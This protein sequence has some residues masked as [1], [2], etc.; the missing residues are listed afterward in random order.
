MKYAHPQVSI[1]TQVLL[2]S[3]PADALRL[4]SK[5]AEKGQGWKVC[6]GQV[7]G[8]DESFELIPSGVIARL[9]VDPTVILDVA[10]EMANET[11]G[12][13][14][15]EWSMDSHTFEVTWGVNS[16]TLESGESGYIEPEGRAM[17]SS[18]GSQLFPSLCDKRRFMALAVLAKACGV[19]VVAPWTCWKCGEVPVLVPGEGYA[20]ACNA[21]RSDDG[22]AE[23][24]GPLPCEFCGGEKKPVLGHLWF[25]DCRTRSR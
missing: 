10:C 11:H 14:S 4:L 20:C 9:P 5:A 7:K 21:E 17:C 25:C 3:L 24:S 22:A 6:L 2:L 19:E 15:A 8:I 12:V 1:H 23:S 18:P 16:L 13:T